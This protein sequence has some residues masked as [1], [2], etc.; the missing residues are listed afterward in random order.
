MN[1]QDNMNKVIK[2]KSKKDIEDLATT[3][4]TMK[5]K[6]GDKMYMITKYFEIN[7]SKGTREHVLNLKV[8]KSNW[9]FR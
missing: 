9:F 4:R 2:I 7:P 5:G 8:N 1:A 3:I 6:L